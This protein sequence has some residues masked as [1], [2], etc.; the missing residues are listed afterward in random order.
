MRYSRIRFRLLTSCLLGIGICALALTANPEPQKGPAI[1]ADDWLPILVAPA[2]PIPVEAFGAERAYPEWQNRLTKVGKLNSPLVE[3]TPFIFKGRRCLLENWQRQWEKI[4]SPDGDRFQEDQVR[5]R[6]LETDEIISVALTGHG[7]GM[8]FVWEGRVYVFAG[9][10]GTEKKWQIKAI[11]MTY[12]DDLIHWS[13]P[14]VVLRAGEGERFFNVSVCRGRDA[15]V[16]LVES[17]DAR[18]PAFTFKYF[19]SDDL[20]D[21]TPVEHAQ[22]GREKYVG[23]PALYFY[24]DYFYTLYLQSLGDGYYETRV[25][26]SKDLVHWQD[27]PVERPV[28]TYDPLQTVHEIRPPEIREKNAS[29]VEIYEWEGKTYAYFTGGD[30]QVGGDLQ[31]AV[32][33]GSAQE[34]LEH[35]FAAPNLPAPRPNQISYQEAQLGAFVHFGPATFAGGDFMQVPAAALFNPSE[36]DADQWMKAAVAMG[37]KHIVL[38]AKHHNGYCL[39][40]TKTTEYSVKGSPWKGGQGDVVREFV[41][42]ARRHGL[43]PGLYLSGGDKSFPCTSTPDPVGERVIEGDRNA[44]Y[45]VFL[46]QLRELLTGYG[47]L[48][49]MW[50]DGA[51]DPFG[52]DVRNAKGEY[53]GPVFGDAAALMVHELQPNAVVFNGT[54]PDI[55]WS[56]SER[57]EAAYP[58]W[59]VV[60]PEVATQ[61][62]CPVYANGYIPAEANVHTRKGWFWEANTDETLLTVDRLIE[63]AHTSLGRGANLLINMT[64]DTRGL[65]P[66]AEVML[67]REFGEQWRSMYGAPIAAIS[68]EDRWEEGNVLT[69]D[70]GGSHRI[71]RVLLEEEFALGQRVKTFRLEVRVGGEW[72]VV[73]EGQTIGRMRIERFDP[74]ETDALRVRVIDTLAMPCIRNVSVYAAVR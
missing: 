57:G 26:R 22:Y 72:K 52:W 24:G 12:S 14:R 50:F 62:W 15:F 53:L 65:V 37:A 1:D 29:D 34:L 2:R 3:V 67:L 25:A 64:P 69:V 51:Y 68:S 40:P 56:G 66:D 32:F 71:D 27:A 18:W 28:V 23:G 5:I 42:A 9:N 54:R 44:Y 55:R 38:T 13:E 73:S 20:I 59:N 31:L 7:L 58:L 16:L 49:A 47:E 41:D 19:T 63:I 17:D 30:Q 39:W 8:A 11:E 10:W 36:L 61:V 60:T 46:E 74:V 43:K 45:P 21:W 6:D 48:S 33:E 35:Y 70:L 4:G